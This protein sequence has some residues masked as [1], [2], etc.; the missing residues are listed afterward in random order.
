M[1]KK[2]KSF[3]VFICFISITVLLAACGSSESTNGEGNKEA[4]SESS[5]GKEL[6]K[7]TQVTNWF[8]EPEHG[9]QYTALAKG[10]YEEVGIDMTIEP[11]GP[12]VSAVQI[13]SSGKAMFGMAQA[14]DILIARKQGIPIVAIAATFQT[15]PQGL[16]Y[17]K[18]Q[19]IKDFSDLNGRTV[20]TM[21]GANYW[22]Y[23]KK[24]Y[25]LNNVTDMAYTGSLVNFVNDPEILTQGYI[26][27][28][29]YSLK[30]QGVETEMLLNA[31]SDYN[32]YANVLFTTENA[33]KENPELVQAF[34]EASIRG[35]DYYKD[36]YEEVNPFIQERNPDISLDAMKYGAETQ[37]E[38][39][40]GGDA[41]GNG[42]GYMTEARWE[43]L[44]DQLVEIK[45]LDE[46]E[47]VNKVFTNEFLPSK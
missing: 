3:F 14:D 5:G 35:W 36:N 33:I 11:G 26:T 16:I 17:H 29:P 20:Y 38:L 13:V 37:M 6:T 30:E 23:M 28:E 8:A 1:K 9:G 39:V 4:E 41:A 46:K 24:K 42:V 27:A 44:M 31:E 32:P 43:T 22:E 25:N 40:Y 34:V 19:D 12:Q 45:M 21:P 7:V 15:N 18:G 47:D 10:F 2:M